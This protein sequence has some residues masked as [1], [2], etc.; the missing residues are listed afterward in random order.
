[1]NNLYKYTEKNTLE[2]PEFYMYSKYNGV[3]FLKDYVRTRKTFLENLEGIIG[4]NGQIE[5]RIST[6]APDDKSLLTILEKF[7]KA[8]K[9][10][11]NELLKYLL[12]ANGQNKLDNKIVYYWLSKLLSRFE[13]KKKLYSFYSNK[14]KPLCDNYADLS[15]YVLL[16]YNL[17]LYYEKSKNLKML[18]GALKLN[19][20]LCSASESE[21]I[22]SNAILILK[23]IKKELVCIQKL[24]DD[25]EV[26]I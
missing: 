22:S 1:M 17:L 9:I 4:D 24:A 3:P 14:M 25:L 7:K 16:S 19:D 10:N 6:N 11:T 20:L 8:D 23:T 26:A 15:N 2:N 12:S 5:P 18:N 13:V 21:K